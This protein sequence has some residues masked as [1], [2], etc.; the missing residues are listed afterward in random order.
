MANIKIE[1]PV[2]LFDSKEAE[3]ICNF[4]SGIKISW[5]FCQKESQFVSNATIKE[6]WEITIDIKQ[7]KYKNF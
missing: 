5:L 4:F 2:R 6:L 3:C 1:I 7:L